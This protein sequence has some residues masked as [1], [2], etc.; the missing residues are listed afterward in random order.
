M[1]VLGLLF[2]VAIVV[3]GYCVYN[4]TVVD[5]ADFTNTRTGKSSSDGC[6]GPFGF[7]S[8]KALNI[9]ESREY[10]IGVV[11]YIDLEKNPDGTWYVNKCKTV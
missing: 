11:S 1:K 6:K 2:V 7:D 5:S 4:P 8:Q 9:S 3:I 10:M